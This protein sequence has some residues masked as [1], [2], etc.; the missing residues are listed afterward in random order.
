MAIAEPSRAWPFRAPSSSFGGSVPIRL[1]PAVSTGK[2]RRPRLRRPAAWDGFKRRIAR[3]CS[4]AAVR[5]Q[6]DP[7]PNWKRR[8]S[9]KSANRNQ[10]QR[11]SATRPPGFGRRIQAGH[12]LPAWTRRSLS[13]MVRSQQRSPRP[14]AP[15]GDRHRVRPPARSS[16]SAAASR[17]KTSWALSAPG[18]F[19]RC[20]GAGASRA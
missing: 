7:T 16:S 12:K 4:S 1:E 5:V 11:P 18:A 3:R 13:G 6:T 15:V 9:P 14:L 10:P 8:S 19:A 2:R 20:R 17:S